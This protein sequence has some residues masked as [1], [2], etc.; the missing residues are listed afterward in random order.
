MLELFLFL[1]QPIHCS[2]Q[3]SP[4]S[5]LPRLSCIG[6]AGRRATQ[7]IRL[8]FCFELVRGLVPVTEGRQPMGALRSRTFELSYLAVKLRVEL[9]E[10]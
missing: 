3:H 7:N 5:L 6:R 9:L 10:L 8:C 1:A 4:S 2:F